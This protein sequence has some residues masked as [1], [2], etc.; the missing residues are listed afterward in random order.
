MY[1]LLKNDKTAHC[2]SVLSHSKSNIQPR[3]TDFKKP[4]VPLYMYI[5]QIYSHT[6]EG[7]PRK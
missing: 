3:S 4:H 6:S 2:Q 7:I 1:K 5:Q